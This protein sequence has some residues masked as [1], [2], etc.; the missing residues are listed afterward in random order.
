MQSQKKTEQQEQVEKLR[1]L[2]KPGDTVYTILRHVSR[3]GMSR[4]IDVI[5]LRRH[6]EPRI[7]THAVAAACKYSYP[8]GRGEGLKADGCGTDMGFEVVYN[9]GR[10]LFPQGFGTE[11]RLAKGATDM[12]GG[13]RPASKEEAELMVKKGWRF[14]GRNGDTSGWDNDGGYA[15]NQRWL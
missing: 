8:R 13:S 6:N 12:K 4:R 14:H 9:L 1:G 3:S 7:I 2:I 15:L 5:L 11:G 10:H